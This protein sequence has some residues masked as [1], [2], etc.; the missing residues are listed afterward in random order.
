LKYGLILRIL[1]FLPPAESCLCPTTIT[2]IDRKGF[3]NELL[4]GHIEKKL[5]TMADQ[6]P[7]QA[8]GRGG[9]VK[10]RSE[11]MGQI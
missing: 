3:N 8:G 7:V 11:K 4:S 2:F 9:L 6:Q 10:I 5:N 1:C